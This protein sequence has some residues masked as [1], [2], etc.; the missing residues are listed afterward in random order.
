MYNTDL[1]DDVSV[2]LSDIEI[3]LRSVPR[4]DDLHR[5]NHVQDYISNYDV[6]NKIKAQKRAGTLYSSYTNEK[7]DKHNLSEKIKPLIQSKFVSG[8]PFIRFEQFK[9]RGLSLGH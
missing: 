6:V 5:E 9:K 7:N 3:W 2:T 4:F 1:F 8:C